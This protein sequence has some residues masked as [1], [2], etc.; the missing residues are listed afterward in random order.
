MEKVINKE[1]KNYQVTTETKKQYKVIEDL[2]KKEVYYVKADKG[3][4]MVV[5]DKSDYKKRME[6]H[7][8]K[9]PYVKVRSKNPLRSFNLKSKAMVKTNINDVFEKEKKSTFANPNPRIPR[10]YGLPKIH[11]IGHPLRPIVSNIGSPTQRIAKWLVDRFNEMMPPEGFS[12]K[13][14][15]EFIDEVRDVLLKPE[16]VLVSFDVS[17]LFPSVPIEPTLDLL[18]TWLR[19]NQIA[20]DQ[21]KAYV[22]LTEFCLTNNF[23]QYDGKFYTQSEGLAMGNPLSPFLANLFMSNFEVELTQHEIFPRIWHRYVDDIFAIVHKDDTS[24]VLSLLNDQNVSIQFTTELEVDAKLA[25]LDLEVSRVEDHLEFNIYRKKTSTQ[26]F[27]R[28]D[29]CHNYQH[30][31]AAFNSM[32]YR[33]LHVPLSPENHEKE[34]LFIK[35]IA[36]EN[37]FDPNIIDRMIVN[38][39]R[40]KTVTDATTLKPLNEQ[41]PKRIAIH[42]I[43]RINDAITKSL[44]GANVSVVNMN[45]NKLRSLLGSTKDK[46]PTLQKSGVYE[47]SCNDCDMKYIGQ[48]CRTI[49]ERFKEHQSKK[50]SAVN[51][52][53]KEMNHTFN[54]KNLKLL[55][56]VNKTWFLD[57]TEALFINNGTNLMNR[58][59]CPINS[60]L[61]N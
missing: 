17:S 30:R 20:E 33:M 24:N 35:N 1:L 19:W 37:G 10:I 25:F 58:D 22:N 7:I 52:H 8:E 13:N 23:F 44:K 49:Q 57:A 47:I 12:V 27:I 53:M 43:P 50:E 51:G 29:S 48:T 55:K 28:F 4:S 61:F 3:N 14:N 18:D 32:I 38:K 5:M 54:I 42:Y 59:D 41:L 46:I 34:H 21:I 9:G 60:I 2:R 16:E 40:Q 31:F 11:K 6:E 39:G 56:E 26:N 45:Q 36:I 15:L